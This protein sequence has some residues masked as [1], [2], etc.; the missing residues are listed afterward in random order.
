MNIHKD[1]KERI[2]R[3][4]KSL[5]SVFVL[6]VFF[7]DGPV[8]AA[9][10]PPPKLDLALK[11]HTAAGKVDYV[12]GEL[13]IEQPKIE[14]NGTLLRM[15][16]V[17]V[18]IPTARYDGD[19]LQASDA[20]GELRLTQKEETPTPTGT[21]R[22]WLTGRATNGDVVVRFKA[23]PRVVDEHTRTGP[24]FDPRTDGGGV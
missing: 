21:Y 3:T 15:P 19:A 1:H 9:E 10:A 17:I 16:L 24:L 8:P 11:P 14:A 22:Q 5:M 20:S 13:T 4:I 7:V 2:D 6:T 18:S 12:E 23:T